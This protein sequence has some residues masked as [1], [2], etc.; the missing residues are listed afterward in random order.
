M[1]YKLGYQVAGIDQKYKLGYQVATMI[2]L[3]N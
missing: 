3:T 2:C 1:K